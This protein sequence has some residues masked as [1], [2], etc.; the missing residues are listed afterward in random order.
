MAMYPMGISH[1]FY[2]SRTI[3]FTLFVLQM[4]W[5]AVNRHRLG[6]AL[7]T[8]LSLLV[9]QDVR[10]M[11]DSIYNGWG[12]VR[13]KV[14]C[15]SFFLFSQSMKQ[16]LSRQLGIEIFSTFVGNNTWKHGE[17]GFFV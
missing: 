16:M 11:L 17:C 12:S 7:I 3:Y 8:R 5:S 4:S 6:G 2:M 1:N 9:P 10:A 15:P 14:C 13:V